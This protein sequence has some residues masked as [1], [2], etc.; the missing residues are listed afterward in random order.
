MRV[1]GK[2]ASE[3]YVI[4]FVAKHKAFFEPLQPSFFE[5]TTAMAFNYFA[6]HE[7]YI[8]ILEVGLG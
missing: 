3:E 1:N 6:E 8:A 7:V 2:P 5:L 4:D